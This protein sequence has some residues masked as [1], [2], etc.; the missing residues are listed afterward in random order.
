MT[1]KVDALEDWQKTNDKEG[2][3]FCVFFYE[4]FFYDSCL[5]EAVEK[6]ISDIFLE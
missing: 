6:R 3:G 1:Q 5:N 2:R 4:R